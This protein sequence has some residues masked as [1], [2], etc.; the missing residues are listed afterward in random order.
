MNKQEKHMYDREHA[1][2][3]EELTREVFQFQIET[4]A[5]L[6]Y[7]AQKR[8]SLEYFMVASLYPEYFVAL[9]ESIRIQPKP[10]YEYSLDIAT[11]EEQKE[12]YQ[13]LLE[14]K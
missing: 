6:I 4:Y 14:S 8:E 3:K 2:I 1:T 9:C 10:A 11:S 12:H 7:L 5:E 13:N